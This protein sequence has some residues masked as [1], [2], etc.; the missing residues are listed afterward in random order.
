MTQ[1]PMLKTTIETQWVGPFHFEKMNFLNHTLNNV[2]FLAP[3][4]TYETPLFASVNRGAKVIQQIQNFQSTLLSDGM[5]RSLMFEAKDALAARELARK[6][7]KQLEFFQKEI[8]SNT[9]RF[10]QLQK[11]D[12]HYVASIVYLR[13]SYFTAN[14]SGH[15]MATLASDQIGQWIVEHYP[16]VRYLSVSGNVC[17][18]KKVSSVNA[19]QGRGKHVIAEGWIDRTIVEQTLRSTPE[20]I[21][22]LNIKKNLLGSIVAGSLLSGNAHYANM[23]LAFYLATGQD[24]ANIVEGSQGITFAEV[25]ENQ[26]YFSVSLP[27]LIVGTVGNGKTG[28]DAESHLKA[29]KI[30]GEFSSQTLAHIAS[31]VVWAGELS[32]LAALTNPH[33]L[34]KSHVAIERKKKS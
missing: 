16:H 15:N 34:I 30:E 27:N 14:A 1:Q 31:A 28:T 11:L 25:R 22:E 24:A 21:V 8:V 12:V 23:L 10:A 9:S 20:K 32:L 13:L 7:E 26:L 17:S 6:I 2:Q 18:D 33:E 29:M 3:L 4:A 5:T 19:I